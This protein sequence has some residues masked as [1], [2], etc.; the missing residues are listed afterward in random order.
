MATEAQDRSMLKA[1]EG[2]DGFHPADAYHDNQGHRLAG[3]LEMDMLRKRMEV[4]LI[5]HP[6]DLT[7]A[8]PPHDICDLL[9]TPGH[10]PTRRHS[11]RRRGGMQDQQ[12]LQADQST[13]STTPKHPLRTLR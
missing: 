1:E 5:V 10:F 9:P 2:T 7:F 11:R 8:N 13:N 12:P 3:G 4:C 6:S